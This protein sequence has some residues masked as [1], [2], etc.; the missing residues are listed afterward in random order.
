MSGDRQRAQ[1]ICGKGL[2]WPIDISVKSVSVND[3]DIHKNI[4]FIF[5]TFM[6]LTFRSGNYWLL[7]SIFL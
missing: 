3:E 1:H 5:F 4:F 6:N 2:I 7:N